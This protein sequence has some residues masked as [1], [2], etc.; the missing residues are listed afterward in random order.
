MLH[1]YGAETKSDSLVFVFLVRVS[2]P[3]RP[4]LNAIKLL[5]SRHLSFLHLG[6]LN[7]NVADVIFRVKSRRALAFI[8]L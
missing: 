4:T 2:G 7:L 6:H 3:N 5:T 1:M 8:G